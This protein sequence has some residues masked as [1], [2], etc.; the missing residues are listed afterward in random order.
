M[1]KSVGFCRV[2]WACLGVSVGVSACECVRLFEMI[3]E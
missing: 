3:K 2:A 1:Y